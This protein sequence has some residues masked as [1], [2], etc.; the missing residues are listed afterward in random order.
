MKQLAWLRH[1]DILKESIS[2]YQRRGNFIWI[3]PAKGSNSYHKYFY[4]QNNMNNL[5]YKF[6]FDNDLIQD[7]CFPGNDEVTASSE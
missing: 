1:W 4:Y 5:L 6:M 3:F 7:E 2:E